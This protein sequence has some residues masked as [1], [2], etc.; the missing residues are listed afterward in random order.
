MAY[1]ANAVANHFLDMATSKGK[2]LTPMK[3]QKLV[4]FAHGWNLALFEEPLIDEPIQAWKFGP[5]VPSLYQEFKHAGN[6]AIV[7]KA[8]NFNFKDF[9]VVTPDVPESDERTR[10]LLDRVWNSYGKLSAIDLSNLTHL[11]NTPWEQVMKESGPDVR[12]AII[13]NDK[14]RDHFKALA[15]KNRESRVGV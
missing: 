6:S 10:A 11:P 14:I 1:D 12:N 5:V 8:T 15:T 13:P 3:L 9:E 4:Y 2:A 7:T